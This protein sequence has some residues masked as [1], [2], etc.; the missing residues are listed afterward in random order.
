M[1]HVCAIKTQKGIKGEGFILFIYLIHMFLQTPLY[2]C[3]SNYI[4]EQRN[5]N[6]VHFYHLYYL[7][8]II[9]LNISIKEETLNETKRKH[10]QKRVG[11]TYVNGRLWPSTN[12]VFKF[13]KFKTMNVNIKNAVL[14]RKYEE[15]YKSILT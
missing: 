7:L 14:F 6:L 5:N 8:V 10:I 2:L 1:I 3:N 15:P 4:S 9:I 11:T 13:L 12:T